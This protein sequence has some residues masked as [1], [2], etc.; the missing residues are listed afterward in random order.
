M[1]NKLEAVIFDWAGTTM[2]YGCY[3]PAVIFQRVFADKGVPISMLEARRPMGKHKKVHLKDIISDPDVAERWSAVH[4]RMP[5]DEDVE[6]MFEAF[7][8]IQLSYLV[9]YSDLISGTLETVKICRESG[10]KIGSTTGYTGEIMDFLLSEAAA[11][12]YM[13]DVTVCATGHYD[14][15]N[16]KM[17]GPFPG[18]RENISRPRPHMCN[19]NAYLLN[20]SDNAAV[21]KVGDTL[22]DIREGKRAGMW[23]IALAGTGNEMYLTEEHEGLTEEQ[24]QKMDPEKYLEKLR[25]AYCSM[26]K[27]RPDFIADS[28]R[29]VPAIILMINSNMRCGERPGD[30]SASAIIRYSEEPAIR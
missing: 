26:A 3:A 22:E 10:L 11:R 19:L 29:S 2:D 25:V 4:K 7:R 16:G 21:V 18:L 23:T 8:P 6:Q 17:Q 30:Y 9:K 13:P 27:E 12:G 14:L 1:T 28:I 5:T 24:I 15:G 20:V